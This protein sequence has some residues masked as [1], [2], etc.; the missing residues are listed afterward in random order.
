MAET[1]LIWIYSGFVEVIHVELSHKWREVIVFKELWKD[2]LSEL[3]RLLDYKAISC[4]VPAYY[5]AVL[6]ILRIRWAFIST[7][8]DDVIGFYQERWQVCEGLLL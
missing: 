3:I 1:V 2:L 5:V 8:I 7:Y 4:V 6:G